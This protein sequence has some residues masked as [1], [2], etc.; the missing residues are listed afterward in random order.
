MLITRLEKS[1]GINT[2][3]KN[4]PITT[5]S[6]PELRIGSNIASEYSSGGKSPNLGATRVGIP[7][8]WAKFSPLA[9][10]LLETTKATWASNSFWSILERMFFNVVPPPEIRTAIRNGGLDKTGLRIFGIE[11]AFLGKR[12]Q[13][14]NCL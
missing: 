14:V 3:F 9:F 4:P 7:R 11:M 6:L 13:Q 10:E 2:C 1:I 5:R 8:S 12:I